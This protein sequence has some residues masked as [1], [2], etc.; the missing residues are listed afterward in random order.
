MPEK[1]PE[2]TK[3]NEANKGENPEEEDQEI[4]VYAS[5]VPSI[6]KDIVSNRCL[7]TYFAFVILTFAPNSIN[8]N[9]GQVYLT[10]ELK[11]PKQSMSGIM[12]LSAPTNILCSILSGYFTAKKPFTYMYYTTVIS[13]L[14]S[15]YSVLVL[16]RTFPRDLSEQQQ[17]QNLFHVAAVSLMSDLAHNFWFTQTN[18]IIMVIADRRIA[19]IHITA[20]T[21]L[22]NMAQFIHKTYIYRMVD[23]LGL[24]V[25]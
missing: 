20:L 14:L 8:Q 6:F 24:F 16:I 23:S 3:I 2:E 13:V 15:S 9:L 4:E 1:N 17:P 25:P 21:S 22:T 5:Q 10:D 19:G 12:V 11:F 7:L 18:A